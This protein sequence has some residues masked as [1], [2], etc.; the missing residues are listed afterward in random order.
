MRYRLRRKLALEA[1]AKAEQ[2]TVADTELE[3]RVRDMR[4]QFKT[5]QARK[6]DPGK[7]RVF[8]KRDLLREKAM[9]WLEEHNTF[10]VPETQKRPRSGTRVN[11]G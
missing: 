6:L 10:K 9:A 11:Y 5:K 8:V 3:E 1:V 4:K 2:L 7:L